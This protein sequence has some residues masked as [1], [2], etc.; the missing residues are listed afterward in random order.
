MANT[1][2]GEVALRLGGETF[3]LRPTFEAVCEIEDAI[4]ASLYEV[5]RRLE[6]AEITAR[7]LVAFAHACVTRAGYSIE[8]ERLGALIVETGTHGVIAALLEYCHNYAFGGRVEKKVAASPSPE[9]SKTGVST[10]E[11]T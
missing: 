8:R 3:V 5:G 7:D 1:A 6:R 10:S 2:R 4:G 9:P 11:N